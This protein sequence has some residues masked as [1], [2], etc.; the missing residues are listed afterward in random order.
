MRSWTIA[1]VVENDVLNS[2]RTLLVRGIDEG[3]T[4]PEY[5]KA[6]R[7][8]NVQYTGTAYGTAAKAGQPIKPYHMET[9]VR[10]NFS[11]VY[12]DSRWVMMN[13][14]DVIEFVPAYQYS[15]I[16]DTRTR[17]TH[18]RMDGKIYP[19]DD[20]IWQ[21]WNPPAGYSCRCYLVPVTSN[22][23]Y[24]VSRPTRV[25]PDPG[26]GGRTDITATRAARKEI[27]RLVGDM[28]GMTVKDADG[29]LVPLR[30]DEF[31]Y[32]DYENMKKEWSSMHFDEI[33][34]YAAEEPSP[35]DRSGKARKFRPEDIYITAKDKA[36]NVQG[37]VIASNHKGVDIHVE[38]LEVNPANRGENGLSGIG[39]N[40]LARVATELEPDQIFTLEAIES[41]KGFYAKIGMTPGEAYEG[42]QSFSFTYEQ[43]QDFAKKMSVFK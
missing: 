29:N 38:F 5:T 42:G 41:A 9:I 18:A 26:F 43:A 32:R 11:T 2:A 27:P 16:L 7:D 23:P 39:S 34:R 33:W 22:H 28:G 20:P 13:H 37:A 24:T 15:A 6:F 14:P 19:R 36:G 40:L 30:A 35:F 17:P 31:N 12:N 1:G 8:A 25:D 10:T 4:L 21:R 3:W